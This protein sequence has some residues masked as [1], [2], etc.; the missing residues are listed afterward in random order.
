MSW[1]KIQRVGSGEGLDLLRVSGSL[2][3]RARKVLAV[4]MVEK[5]MVSI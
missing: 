3:I 2:C 1:W 4:M 5:M